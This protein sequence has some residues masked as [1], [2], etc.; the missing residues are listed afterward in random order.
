M[1]KE[2]NL[3]TIKT[4]S[5]ED[6]LGPWATVQKTHFADGGIYDQITTKQN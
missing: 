2:A 5:V 3:L 6:K 1:L 4:F